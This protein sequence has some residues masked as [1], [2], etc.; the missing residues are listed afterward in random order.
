MGPER[1]V[2]SVVVPFYNVEDYLGEC[3]ESL[4]NQTLRD[5]EVVMVDDGSPDGSAVIAKS[6]A[7]RDPRFRLVQQ[8]NRGLGPARNTGARHATGRYLAFVD[9]DDVVARGAFAL[10]TGTLERTG[11]DFACGNVHRFDAGRVWQSWAHREPFGRRALRTHVTRRTN[12]MQDRMV[13]NKVFRRDFWDRHGLAFPGML[14]EDSPVMVRAHVLADSV[15]VLPEHVYYWRERPGSITQRRAELAN[16]EDRIASVRRVRAF[17]DERAPLLRPCYDRYAV[18][19]DLGVLTEA[20]P[21]LAEADRARAV[22]LGRECLAGTDPRVL[23]DLAPAKRLRFHLLERGMLPE[24][25]EI[26]EARPDDRPAPRT[27]RRGLLRPRF[28]TTL[29]YF[30][31]RSKGVPD[32]VYDVTD[33]LPLWAF[34]DRVA[35]EDGML[36][37]EGWAHISS[38]DVSR[39]RDSRVRMWLVEP[40][41]RRRVPLEVRRTRRPEVTARSGQAEVSYDWAGFSALI[42]PERLRIGRRWRSAAWELHVEVVTRGLRRRG[43]VRPTRAPVLAWTPCRDVAPGVRVKPVADGGLTFRVQCP[44]ADLTGHRLDGDRLEL[45]GTLAVRP[46]RATRLVATRLSGGP[47][48]TGPAEVTRRPDGGWAFRAR[49]PLAALRPAAGEDGAEGGAM[50]A[51]ITDRVDWNLSLETAGRSLRLAMPRTTPEGRYPL[52]GD[53]E[54]AVTSTRFGNLRGVERRRRPVVDGIRW[55]GDTLVLTGDHSGPER[56]DRIVLA[57]HRCGDHHR[58]PLTWDGARFTGRIAPAAMERFGLRTPLT[59]GDWELRLP[60]PATGAAGPVTVVAERRLLAALPEERVVG[61]HAVTV[62]AHRSD[63]LRLR[64]RLAL[65]EEDRGARGRRR[66]RT[67]VYPALLRRPVRDLVVFDC[68]EGRQYACNPRAV[69]EEIRRRDLGLEYVWV[70]RDGAF[71]T[72]DGARIALVDSRD[73]Y[74]ALARARFVVGNFGQFPWYAKRPGQT[75]L[76]TWHGTPLKRLVYDLADMPWERT[77]RFDWV[78]REVPRWD[79]L[80]SPNPFTT[81]I[82]RRA[83]RYDGEIVETGYPRNDV[84][85]GPDAGRVAADTRA[86]LGVPAGRKVILYAPTWRDDHHLAPGRRAFSLELDIERARHALGHDHVLLVRTHYLVTDRNWS[87]DDGFVIDVSAYPDIADL[88]LAA[89][90]LVTDYSSAMFDFAVTGKPIFCYAYDLERYRDRVRGFY[91]DLEAEA[92]GPV[93][94]TTGDLVEAIREDD[95]TAHPRYAAFREKFCPFDD[96]H[97]AARVVDRLLG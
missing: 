46:G 26:L 59:S 94:R 29:P 38:L 16:L 14:Y 24:L 3:L 5:I 10:M 57:H 61:A 78:E 35:W 48:V 90:L 84:L 43:R 50:A 42:D 80:L 70:S 60:D 53:R 49:L 39:E 62:D 44:R 31:D 51:R 33:R 73:H 72:P 54:F 68:Y 8:D 74:E 93:V 41:R 17:L 40:K 71:P 77:E 66:L 4:A 92:P 2:L 88:Y 20:L 25:L 64:V 79:V 9:S 12:L 87:A 76:Q 85:L 23:R 45:T 37:V 55:D 47:P 19:V 7:D 6:Y 28:Y 11:S 1:A 36:R 91:F 96:G 21:H 32:E 81:P 58:A 56:P 86:R 89:D 97:A 27:V 82:M 13:W 75:Y 18:D 34:A 30:R 22:E 67:E 15:D 95:G 65:P 63:A 69:F 52:R 83:F